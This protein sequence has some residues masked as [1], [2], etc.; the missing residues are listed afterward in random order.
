MTTRKVQRTLIALKAN[1]DY[2]LL[3]N[4]RMKNESE[5]TEIYHL[6]VTNERHYTLLC[7]CINKCS[8]LKLKSHGRD[9]QIGL[10]TREDLSE[11]GCQA[12]CPPPH[13]TVI[14]VV[15]VFTH[16]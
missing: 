7:V 3:A 11:G 13:N 9:G 14:A 12:I 5:E 16:V 1:N 10:F 8:H 2:H 15:S 6:R 4:K